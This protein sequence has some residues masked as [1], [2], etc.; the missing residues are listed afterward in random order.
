MN[1]AQPAP[2]VTILIPAQ[3]AGQAVM[4][5]I[6]SALRQTWEGTRVVVAATSQA[7]H[8]ALRE[9]IISTHVWIVTPPEGKNPL[10]HAMA[11]AVGEYILRLDPGTSLCHGAIPRLL[12]ACQRGGVATGPGEFINKKGRVVRRC[13]T[14]GLLT[15][16]DYGKLLCTPPMLVKRYRD[17]PYRDLSES[18]ALHDAEIAAVTDCIAAAEG[19]AIWQRQ[20]EAGS[21][22]DMRVAMN[23]L[24]TARR[25]ALYS[26]RLDEDEYTLDENERAA[27]ARILRYREFVVRRYLERLGFGTEQQFDEFIEERAMFTSAS[28]DRRY[29]L[30]QTAGGIPIA[31]SAA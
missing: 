19:P 15:A 25:L 18:G 6:N 13:R 31:A 23:G 21:Y 9:K 7:T 1:P 16:Q 2:K 27:A 10:N 4:A 30:N 11:H 3:D 26:T 8:Q 24:G 5:S 29:G 14:R 12:R 20:E 28:F 17:R 22:Q